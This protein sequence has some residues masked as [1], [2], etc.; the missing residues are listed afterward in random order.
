MN[1][2]LCGGHRTGKT[3]LAQAI[4]QHKNIPFVKTDTSGV[5]R[6]Y[7]LD[8]AL[9][10]D[11]GTRL[12]I[13]HRVLEAAIAI[14]EQEE[15]FFISDR[16]PI[17]MMAYTIGDI[18]GKT[19]VNFGELEDYLNLCF[20]ATN[21]F[22]GKLVIIQPGIPLVYEVGK[23]ALNQAYI[24]HINILV[25]GLCSDRRLQSKT[26]CLDRQITNLDERIKAVLEFC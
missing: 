2:G 21:K 24:E 12:N 13:Q 16:T 9:P 14:W 6:K 8:P 18:Q 26:V 5:F 17:D 19:E 7:G 25:M 23:A 1:L 20:D 4:A 10:M 15:N 22:F 3:T 11:F